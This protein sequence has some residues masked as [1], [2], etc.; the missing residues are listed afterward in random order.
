MLFTFVCFFC[1]FCVE[2]DVDRITLT[3]PPLPIF[4]P[5]HNSYLTQ[6]TVIS[7]QRAPKAGFGAV[8]QFSFIYWSP[9][10]TF[11]GEYHVKLWDGTKLL[12]FAES[13]SSNMV[14]YS[15][16]IWRNGSIILI[17]A[18]TERYDTA[19]FSK[20]TTKSLASGTGS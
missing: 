11:P 17:P 13:A 9:S 1:L 3:P 20:V 8:W 14:L 15:R 4:F 10:E 19:R 18:E 16:F 6:V 7:N 12:R 2:V 5:T